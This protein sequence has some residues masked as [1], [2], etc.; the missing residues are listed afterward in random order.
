MNWPGGVVFFA[1]LASVFALARY[2]LKATSFASSIQILFLLFLLYCF[3]VYEHENLSSLNSQMFRT[4]SASVLSVFLLFLVDLVTPFELSTKQTALIL[5]SGAVLPFLNCAVW[6]IFKLSIKPQKFVVIG[7]SE[8][9]SPVVEELSKQA[10]PSISVVNYINPD[11]SKLESMA[12]NIAGVIVA[13]L[14]YAGLVKRRLRNYQSKKIEYLAELVEKCLK[15]IPQELIQ[16]NE[17]Y[18]ISEFSKNRETL[19]LR[20]LDVCVSL[21]VL[22][23]SLPLWL[24]ISLAILI[25]DGRPV[26][27]KQERV[28]K[29]GKSFVIYKFRSMRQVQNET[30]KFADEEQHRIL[31]VGRLL[32]KFRLDELPQLINVLKGDMSLVGPRP[33]QK[34]FV[35]KFSKEIPYYE[36]RLKVKP[37]I[38]GWAQINYPYTS[39]TEETAKKLEYDLWYIKH[40][41]FWLN[42]Q[43][44]LKTPETMLFRRGAK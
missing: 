31:K 1:D 15:R 12:P 29:D 39:S 23:L 17:Q 35:E 21:F 16:K 24:L 26:I 14:S 38:T 27:F 28:G 4:L 10:L 5:S 13:D 7:K 20:L 40:R 19:A 34:E 37:G 33:E 2:V 42:L 6:R 3:R 44:I 25:E 8:E 9:Y 30:A 22:V 36:Y 18:Y 32:R 43:I 11:F 41:N